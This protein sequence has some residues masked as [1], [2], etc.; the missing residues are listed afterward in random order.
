MALSVFPQNL[1][2]IVP[3]IRLRENTM[4]LWIGG[5]FEIKKE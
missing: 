2:G 5:E 4:T 1:T 3:F